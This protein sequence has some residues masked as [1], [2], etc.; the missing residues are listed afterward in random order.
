MSRT[1]KRIRIIV[2][3]ELHGIDIDRLGKLAGT[4][5]RKFGGQRAMATITITGDAQMRKVHYEFLR[6]RTT[7]DV[8]SFD[9]TDEFEKTPVFELVVNAEMAA[10][11][12]R[13]RGHTTEAELALYITHGLLHNLGFDDCEPEQACLMH[14]TEDTLLTKAGFGCVFYTLEGRKSTRAN[15]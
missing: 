9:L 13:E 12:A 2:Q 4:V 7:T 6:K 5:L 1:E 10:R 14:Q 8:I 15:S 3:T 11:Q